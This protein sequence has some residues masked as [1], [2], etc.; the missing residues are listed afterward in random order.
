M[1]FYKSLPF[2]FINFHLPFPIVGTYILANFRFGRSFIFPSWRLH[3]HGVF[4]KMSSD[5]V[6]GFS[7]YFTNFTFKHTLLGMGFRVSL[8]TVR[9][10]EGSTTQI[11][12]KPKKNLIKLV[13]FVCPFYWLIS[14]LSI[15]IL[16]KK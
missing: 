8:D 5:L 9:T 14:Y 16:K 2:F 6:N 7:S 13:E 1:S 11:T 15:S 12:R 3:V 4:Q 10:C